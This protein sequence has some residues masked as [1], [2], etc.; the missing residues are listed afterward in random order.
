VFIFYIHNISPNDFNCYD[1]NPINSNYCK[2]QLMKITTK[3]KSFNNQ[4]MDP[5]S[6]HNSTRNVYVNYWKKEHNYT[7]HKNHKWYIKN[8][9]SSKCYV[10]LVY[11][12]YLDCLDEKNGLKWGRK[13]IE[14]RENQKSQYELSGPSPTIWRSRA[15]NKNIFRIKKI[16]FF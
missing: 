12:A 9:I 11:A 15:N 14:R 5:F 6:S 8:V 10:S 3:I 1:K 2:S 13:S 16:Q 4:I 7:T